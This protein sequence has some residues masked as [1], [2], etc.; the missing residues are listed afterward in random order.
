MLTSRFKF[1]FLLL[2]PALAFGAAKIRNADIASDAAIAFSKMAALTTSKAV[3][4]NGSGVAVVSPTTAAQIGYSS[5]VTSMIQ[6]QIDGKQASGNYIVSLASDV[7]ATGPG[8]VNATIQPG[9]IDNGK[10]SATAAITR[11]KLASGTNYRI[12]ANSSSG[13]MSENAAITGNKAVASDVNGQLAASTTSDTE[14]GYV[15]GVTS[16]IQTQLNAKQASGNYITSLTTDVVASGAGA[17]AATIQ[18]GVVSN[19][20]LANMANATTKCRTTAGTGAPEDCTAAQ[21]AAILDGFFVDSVGTVDSQTKSANGA[22]MTAGGVL[23]LQTATPGFPGMASDGAQTFTGQKKFTS[24]VLLE[25]PGAGT[26][27]ITLAVPTLASDF[28]F[29][30]PSSDG[31]NGQVYTKTADGAKWSTPSAGTGS[32]V[33]TVSFGNVSSFTACTSSPCTMY[34]HSS[35]VSSVTRTSTGNY[36]VN[37]VA[38]T[39]SDDPDCTLSTLTNDL[40]FSANVGKSAT[41]FTFTAYTTGAA[42]VDSAWD[43]ICTE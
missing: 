11:S 13:V 42:A 43:V 17:A 32:H 6:A 1:L 39:W 37:F 15:A 30:M 10:I 38:A 20:K 5:D 27:K 35:G 7:V 23:V 41:T 16:A 4:T 31:T 34:Q 36:S 22:V 33:E 25:D 28:N 21:E 8:A 29:P 19:S 14:L 18:P 12:V 24:N 26:N 2:I 3:V 40:R 9:V